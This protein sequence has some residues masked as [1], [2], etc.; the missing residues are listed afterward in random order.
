MSDEDLAAAPPPPPPP[1]PPAPPGDLPRDLP[2][3]VAVEVE[4]DDELTTLLMSAS[5]LLSTS[6]PSAVLVVAT[7][8]ALAFR[9]SR[10]KSSRSRSTLLDRGPG[11]TL[12]DLVEGAKVTPPPPP[13][14][15]PNPG[16]A[17]PGTVT[18]LPPNPGT[19]AGPTAKAPVPPPAP[20]PT[21]PPK[22]PEAL[23]GRLFC[24]LGPPPPALPL[25]LD[26]MDEPLG[27]EGRRMEDA[28]GLAVVFGPPEVTPVG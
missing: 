22:L 10:T 14:P 25:P 18:G 16:P 9:F 27:A 2:L 28:I 8:F 3:D 5:S 23:S 24:R 1:P 12:S 17:P 19:T 4:V 20:P 21:T 15:P 11:I 7:L 13:P 6:S 26:S